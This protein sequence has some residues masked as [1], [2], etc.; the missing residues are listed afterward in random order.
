MD[1]RL[2]LVDDEEGIR[3]VLGIVLSDLGYQVQTADDGRQGL[4]LFLKHKP[5][6]VITDIKMPAMDGVAL[7]QHI[8]QACPD[9]EV[10]VLTGHGDMDLAIQCLKLEATDF[11]TKPIHDDALEIALKRANERIVMR[12]Q[13]RAYTE[14]LE[15]LVEE[16]SAQ[17]VAAERRTAVGQALEGVT[18]AMRNIAGDLEGGMAYFNDLPCLVSI[19]AP[20]L[21]VV[22]A[23]QRYIDKLGD[24]TGRPGGRIYKQTTPSPAEATFTTGQG[25]RV[26]TV[27][28]CPDGS[29]LPVIV[30]TAPIRDAGGQVA[31]VVEIAADVV[32]VRRLQEQLNSLGM[33][34]GSVSHGIK[35]LL[36]GLD[37]GIYLL[38]RGVAKADQAQIKE[39][40]E[41]VRVIIARIRNLVLDILFY[42]KEKEL[43]WQRVDVATFAREVAD[44]IRSKI[45]RHHIEFKVELAEDLAASEVDPGM[46]QSILA[47]LFDNAVAACNADPDR[48]KRHCIEFRVLAEAAHIL[49][50]VRDNGPGMDAETQSKIFTPQIISLKKEGSG[51]GLFIAHQILR[52]NNGHISLTSRPGQGTVVTI[53]LPKTALPAPPAPR[54]SAPETL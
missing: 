42:A 17:L 20:D 1:Q 37:G 40:W 15:R 31:L 8:K 54:P 30:H 9:T 12:R 23:N 3:K 34:I 22:A 10:I 38:D 6:I 46:L 2:L 25:Q 5:P 51:L 14:N 7:L 50:E 18:A 19:H 53:R 43:K 48:T 16:K 21:T 45:E 28:A 26:S 32:E 36:T 29:E 4:D 13:L 41:T 52:K 24:P 11:V 49:F 27:I 44:Q 33:M 47:N 35:G 39:G